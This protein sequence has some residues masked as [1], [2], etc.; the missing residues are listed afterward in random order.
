MKGVP[1]ENVFVQQTQTLFIAFYWLPQL[2]Q[3]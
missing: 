2:K 3:M 1:T